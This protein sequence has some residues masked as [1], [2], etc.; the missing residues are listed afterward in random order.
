[1][2]GIGDSWG[3]EEELLHPRGPNG[4]WIRKAG[5]AKS[6]IGGVLDFLRNFRP[7]S[8]QSQ[9][10]ATQYLHNTAGKAGH[11]MGRLDHVRLRQDLPHANADLRDGVIDEPSTKRFVDMMD[12]NS[13]ELPDDL[14]LTRVVGVDAFGFTPETANGTDENT[15]PGIRGMS[16]KLVADRGYGLHVVGEPTPGSVGPG[17]VRMIV[18]AKKGTKVVIP[19]GDPSDPTIFT[20]RDQ[21]LRVTRVVPDG[22]GGWNMYVTAD[23][24]GGHDV[25]EPIAGPV[26]PGKPQD[27][28]AEIRRLA[29]MGER[30]QKVPDE[31][32]D[33]A[34]E[35]ARRQKAAEGQQ[36]L[37]QEQ[38]RRDEQARQQ[39]TVR[40]PTQTSGPPP[41]QP[42]PG[43]PPPRTE[44]IVHPSLGGQPQAGAPA[45]TPGPV[46]EAPS[47]PR[48]SV[49]LKL[50]V[51]DAG[52]ESP[53]AGSRR[54]Q[55][56]EAYLGVTSGKKDPVDAVRELDNDI[57]VL[58]GGG[59]PGG[60]VRGGTEE[61]READIKAFEGLRD[62]I[63]EQYGLPKRE[64]PAPAKK[65][66]RAAKKAAPSGMTPEQE[67][68]VV[69]RAK[70]FRGHERN[71]EETRIVR[72][73]DE[74]LARQ[75]GETPAPA[76]KA[77]KKAAPDSGIRVVETPLGPVVTAPKAEPSETQATTKALR[78]PA[79]KAQ[80]PEVQATKAL[81]APAKK[82]APETPGDDLDKMT[83][84]EL[85]EVATRE[86]VTHAGSKTKDQLKADIRRVREIGPADAGSRVGKEQRI[87]DLLG[88]KKKPTV[89]ELRAYAQEQGLG[90]DIKPRDRRDDLIDKILSS[91]AQGA[92]VSVP[93]EQVR[94]TRALDRPEATS[95]PAKKA[96]KAVTPSTPR[97]SKAKDREIARQ[98]LSQV[99]DEFN[100]D[101]AMDDEG[102]VTGSGTIRDALQNA[103]D[104][105]TSGRELEDLLETRMSSRH[106]RG[107]KAEIVQR[108]VDL[109]REANG[110]ESLG[111]ARARMR[112]E[113]APSLSP[114]ILE[115][116]ARQKQ[117]RIDQA[118]KVGRLGNEIEELVDSDASTEAL[119]SRVVARAKR[120]GIPESE[121]GALLEAIDGADRDQVMVEAQRLMDAEGVTPVGH[122]GDTIPFDPKEHKSLGG[123]VPEGTLVRVV[124]PGHR[125]RVDNESVLS[126]KAT[127]EALTPE[128]AQ[129]HQAGRRLV[130]EGSVAGERPQAP[131]K[132]EP[133]KRSFTDAWDAAD[134]QT[135]DD[136]G[137]TA[138]REIRDDVASGKITPEE[139]I[140]RIEGEISFFQDDLNELDANLRQPDLTPEERDRLQERATRMTH[141]IEEQKRASK[142]MRMYFKD[143][144]PTAEE[145]KISLP[146]DQFEVIQNATPET[147]REAAK[148]QGLDPPKGETKDEILQ[149][150]VRQMARRVSE[151]KTPTP[152]GTPVK[153]AAKAAKK[154]A[155]KIPA[156]PEKLDVRTIGTGIDFD[157][158]DQWTRGLLEEAQTAL[159]GTRLS[160]MPR[161][162]GPPS[163]A[164]V[165]KWLEERTHSRMTTAVYEHGQGHGDSPVMSP[166]ENAAR[167]AEH[168]AAYDRVKANVDRI[169]EL[170]D[171]L[172][173]T[174]R[175]PVKKAATPE[176]QAVQEKLDTT[177]ATLLNDRLERLR[178]ARTRE[179]AL[180][181][182]DGLT[183]ADLRRMGEQAGIKGRT[184]DDLRSKL[185][186]RFGQGIAPQSMAEVPETPGGKVPSLP[187]RADRA[188][189]KR[190]PEVLSDVDSAVG[191]ADRR[192]RAGEDPTVVA[193]FLR[194]RA[195]RVSKADLAEEERRFKV[196]R[197]MESMRE[198]RKS[199]A[200]YLRRV[201][202]HVQQE[203][204][205]QRPTKAASSH[206]GLS[207]IRGGGEGGAPASR[208]LKVVPPPAPPAKKAAKAAK[209][210]QAEEQMV[211]NLRVLQRGATPEE[212]GGGTGMTETER[213]A[214][215]KRLRRRAQAERELAGM[216]Q[217]N[218]PPGSFHHNKGL[219]GEKDA[220]RLDAEADA[221][222]RA[223]APTPP[224]PVK[225]AAKKAAPK[226]TAPKKVAEPTGPKM[227][228]KPILENHWGT[229]TGEISFHRDGIIGDG[230]RRMGEDQKLEVD[231]DALGNVLGRLAT[232]AQRGQISQEQLVE[233]LKRLSA[234]L[235]AGSKARQEVE[236][237]AS[238]LDAPDRGPLDLPDSTPGPVTDLMR[239]LS[240]IPLARGGNKRRMGRD[241]FNEMEAVQDVVKE[242]MDRYP[243]G[244]GD[245]TVRQMRILRRIQDQL[246]IKVHN[247]R[248]ESEEGKA[249]ID[250][251]IVRAMQ[252]LER[253]V[254]EM[255]K[256]RT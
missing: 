83:K 12:R 150:L 252:E 143:E 85:T 232:R 204:K 112:G 208:A 110:K 255:R 139:G 125:V 129:V 128:E 39:P 241:G 164:A 186:E 111:A 36:I 253:M 21:P 22:Q 206:G 19:A 151:G 207:L 116:G 10:Q 171:R 87:M 56:N 132:N 17:R 124:R 15:D 152:A 214:E 173:R 6:I 8:F 1:M 58:R 172:K 135:Q 97:R 227:S 205:A 44:Q 184:K 66:T 95:T 248:H 115:E 45:P 49:D 114:Q 231:D 221:L 225:K 213:E 240:K 185:V 187:I 177:Q 169:R 24:H 142:F 234:R 215:V 137:D 51:R 202:T 5:I 94:A 159:D 99:L 74:I 81:R 90:G 183:M 163:P 119:R 237:M 156:E 14:I 91:V 245:A 42:A 194:E 133:R 9:G 228:D 118:R 100:N 250:R 212:R 46:S 52:V 38:A 189:I 13:T 7:R 217:A 155:P 26:G 120:E 73:A 34:D 170:A 79:K 59:E 69:D 167:R 68:A 146:K 210:A 11:R 160:D 78:T 67:R 209:K 233:E 138:L 153:K 230:I 32:K 211:R 4:R 148:I 84:K 107:R 190:P 226:K 251:A 229:G 147:L 188:G 30:G 64:E 53:S 113:G 63:A 55:W 134:F 93:E 219:Q 117:A 254:E 65:A 121:L 104:N 48:R 246:R 158:N 70:Q 199:S 235:P 27:R 76:K 106:S 243:E 54:K 166:E 256:A 82:A 140:R 222:E 249:E 224:A 178:Q 223:G 154:V 149:D 89:A 180:E 181:S 174:R 77:A 92:G 196:S 35:E 239:E 101:P 88:T 16:G 98:V 191:E 108:A 80:A 23:S 75:R 165:G 61:H 29:G 43:E 157:E 28:E 41:R 71:E 122:S 195:A 131:I 242:A 182:L 244:E 218:N 136:S 238:D 203:K 33:L 103:L 86:G 141:T 176:V 72:T 37:Q 144:K 3:T 40:A 57:K 168:Q 18:A 247:H 236:R 123:S 193:R 161:G 220:D 127:V 102:A 50:A 126:D 130:P 179:K 47:T 62:V 162:Q 197:D 216:R 96:A 109:F 200:E 192:L 31:Q 145:F 2:A 25:P 198:L 201:A 60:A 175:R 20:D 105:G